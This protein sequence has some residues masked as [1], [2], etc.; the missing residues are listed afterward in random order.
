MLYKS[1][2]LYNFYIR[3]AQ[4][5]AMRGAGGVI[6]QK[7]EGAGKGDDDAYPKK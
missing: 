2:Y 5:Q 4:A 3:S 1:T 7:A 6:V